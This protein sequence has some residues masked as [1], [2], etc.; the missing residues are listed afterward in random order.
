MNEIGFI[1]LVALIFLYSGY[2]YA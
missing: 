2:Y 1:S